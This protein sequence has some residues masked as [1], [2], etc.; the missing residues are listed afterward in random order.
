MPDVKINAVVFGSQ[1]HMM[2]AAKNRVMMNTALA[3]TYTVPVAG[4]GIYRPVE[5]TVLYKT[6]SI[7][8]TCR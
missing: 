4:M 6:H 7:L 2:M 3:P 5:S 8:G 1:I